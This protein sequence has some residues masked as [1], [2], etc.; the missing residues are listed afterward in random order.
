MDIRTLIKQ[1]DGSLTPSEKELVKQILYNLEETAMLP[2]AEL[3]SRVGVHES[4]AIRLVQKLGFSGYRDFR[5]ALREE[6]LDTVEYPDRIQR[7]LARSHNLVDLVRDEVRA[8]EAMVESISQEDLNE[9]ATRM[10][11]ARR[12]YLYARGHGT[13][14]VEMMDRRL[15]R[16]GLDTVDLRAEGRDLAEHV[17]TLG[18]EDVVLCIVLRHVQPGF[19]PLMRHARQVNASTIAIADTIGPILRPRPDVL[20]W[21]SRGRKGESLTHVVPLTICNA[22]FLTIAELDEERTFES[23]KKVANLVHH[24]SNSRIDDE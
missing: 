24:Y 5:R 6:V 15:R 2:A 8:L 19:G 21:A 18:P 1:H 20:L 10:I 23:L 9:A 4:T 14:M 17:V 3:A 22:L 11:E 7:R 16:Y 13:L 12:V